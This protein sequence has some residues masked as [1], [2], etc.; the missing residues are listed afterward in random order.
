[1]LFKIVVLKNFTKFIRKF[2]KKRLLNRCFPVSFAKFLKN[3][4]FYRTPPVAASYKQM[5][6]RECGAYFLKAWSLDV[7]CTKL[8][9]MNILIVEIFVHGTFSA[10]KQLSRNTPQKNGKSGFNLGNAKPTFLNC[11]LSKIIFLQTSKNEVSK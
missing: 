3:I 1:M 4:I 11:D 9:S 6:L 2:W 5:K 8:V 7:F 10:L